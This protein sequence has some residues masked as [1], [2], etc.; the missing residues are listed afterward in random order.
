M[1]IPIIMIGL[2][3]F[4]L[5]LWHSGTGAINKERSGL[6][7]ITP[8]VSILI[9]A[10]R[11]EKTL[12]KTLESVKNLDYPRKQ[13]I[14][15]NDSQEDSK[16]ISTICKKHKV[17]FIQNRK[18]MGK[19]LSLNNA[20][21]RA[22]GEIIF[23]LDSDTIVERDTLK[24]MIPWFSL[25]D[26]GAV[27]PRYLVLNKS[28]LTRLVSLENSSIFTN[29]KIHMNFGSMIG[30]RGCGIAIKRRALEE[31]GGW[32]NTLME[33]NDL[34]LRMFKRGFKIKFEPRAIVRTGEPET[35]QELQRQRFRWG[36]GATF[37]FLRNYKTYLNSPQFL[38]YFFPYIII[39]LATLAFFIWG[40]AS[41]SLSQYNPITFSLELLAILFI[42]LF[43]AGVMAYLENNSTPS[44]TLI[45]YVFTHTPKVMKAYWRG[46]ISGIKSMK[47]KESELMLE[48][49]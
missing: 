36:K 28:P 40:I 19:A 35:Y 9:P 10:Y 42:F 23:F 34:A 6:K 49:W 11:S 31:L 41:I 43:H 44:P 45:N 27:S 29:L 1:I 38:L 15:A 2:T 5:G 37:I 18:R 32:R 7:N 25:K 3:L 30:F 16:R 46:M 8:D 21:K 48:E 22:K 13:V 4:F 20:L 24:K 12:S 14:V 33:D 47:R 26:T 39:G 17:M